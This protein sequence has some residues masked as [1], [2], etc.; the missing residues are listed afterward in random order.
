MFTKLEDT[1]FGSKAGEAL[2]GGALKGYERGKKFSQEIGLQELKQKKEEKTNKAATLQGLENSIE[3][4]K[5]LISAGGVGLLGQF[6]PS[7]DARYRRGQMQTLKGELLNYYKSLFPRGLTQQEFTKLEKDY[8]PGTF[9]TEETMNGKL[10]AF[11]DLIQRKLKSEGYASVTDKQEEQSPEEEKK[12][13][14][15]K[16]LTMRDPS[17]ALRKVSSKQVNE[18]KKYGYKVIK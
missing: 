8:L 10:D 12:E 7:S 3:Q 11:K 9:D 4:M 14:K 17:G 1:N 5:G 16:F 13:S 2:A 15:E 6:N 18:A